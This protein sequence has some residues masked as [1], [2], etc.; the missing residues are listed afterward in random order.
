MTEQRVDT[1]IFCLSDVRSCSSNIELNLFAMN[2]LFDIDSVD[3]S[4]VADISGFAS[5]I[6]A[7]AN[8]SGIFSG[9]NFDFSDARELRMTARRWLQ[10][11]EERLS[12]FTAGEAL[13]LS[14]YYDLVHRVG[15]DKAAESNFLNRYRMNAFE[16]YIRGDTSVDQY[17]LYHV[18]ANEVSRRKPLFLS[19]PLQWM[20]F[21]IEEWYEQFHKSIKH[22]TLSDYDVLQRITILLESNLFAFCGSQ[23]EAFK[24]L[25]VQ[26]YLPLTEKI[27]DM[28]SI[29]QK[30]LLMFVRSIYGKYL[31]SDTAWELE[32]EIM[33]SL[34][35]SPSLT[36]HA[37]QAY[38]LD[39]ELRKMIEVA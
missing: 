36:P 21:C 32:T 26:T 35:T 14:D 9:K 2:P 10:R 16:A 25:L 18:V 19:R 7:Q 31:D 17:T 1:Y 15:F 39:C 12:N 5:L 30:S 20:A 37:R 29:T 34:S 38:R 24:Q 27:A 33:T 4:N 22:I 28:D 8:F 11:V 3:F 6:L 23:Q 13:T